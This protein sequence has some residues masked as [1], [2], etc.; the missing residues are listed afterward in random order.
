MKI[1]GVT[2]EE[3]NPIAGSKTEE[4]SAQKPA[5]PGSA[6]RANV[7]RQSGYGGFN[8][9][10]MNEP[11]PSLVA[12][13]IRVRLQDRGD[14]EDLSDADNDNELVMDSNERLKIKLEAQKR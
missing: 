12:N 10:K 14:E 1:R 3:S 6:N 11:P 5:R 4:G 9:F 13:N 8:G 7:M 2:K